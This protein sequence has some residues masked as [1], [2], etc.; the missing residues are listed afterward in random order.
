MLECRA[1]E[2]SI[3]GIL[4]LPMGSIDPQLEG[5]LAQLLARFLCFEG[6]ANGPANLASTLVGGEVA[7]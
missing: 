1:L 6:D 7:Q 4:L 5:L 2:L 3:E